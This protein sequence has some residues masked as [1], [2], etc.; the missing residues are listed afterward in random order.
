[1]GHLSSAAKDLLPPRSP[2]ALRA[3]VEFAERSALG[4]RSIPTRWG[5]KANVRSSSDPHCPGLGYT[6]WGRLVFDRHRGHSMSQTPT[7]LKV[8]RDEGRR[9]LNERID[10]A[11][12]V[13]P[14]G[15]ILT[16]DDLQRAIERETRTGG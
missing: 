8:P 6:I 13:A 14:A 11:V 3:T 15:D 10:K 12:E 2:K 1:R 9:L 16:M 4:V 5:S 7:L